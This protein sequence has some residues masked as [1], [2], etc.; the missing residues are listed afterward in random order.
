MLFDQNGIVEKTIPY[1][2]TMGLEMIS[3]WIGI[4]STSLRCKLS[5][6]DDFWMI[7]G[8]SW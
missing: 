1:Y 8:I 6:N 5:F 4:T 2:S 7:L 3:T